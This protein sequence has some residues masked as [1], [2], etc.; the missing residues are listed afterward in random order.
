[1]FGSPQHSI[2]A[3]GSVVLF[4]AALLAGAHAGSAAAQRLGHRTGKADFRSAHI[5]AGIVRY[6]KGKGAGGSQASAGVIV[7]L[8]STTGHASN[9]STLTIARP[10]GRPGK[11]MLATVTAP[12]VYN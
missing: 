10:A 4:G 7:L 1:M 5:R 3:C 2:A 6:L 8:A 9:A 11:L 12:P